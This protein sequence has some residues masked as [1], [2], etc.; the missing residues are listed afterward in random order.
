MKAAQRQGITIMDAVKMFSTERKA[1]DW[2]I[3]QRWADG[4]RC[5]RCDSDRVRRQKTRRPMPF[6]CNPCR[7]Y[8]SVKTGTPMQDSNLPLTK[9][10]I[11]FYLYSTNLKGVSSNKLH[12]DL[13]ITQ[14]SAW[15]MA[16][17]IR[18]I[19]N[20]DTPKFSGP[21]EVDETYIG[22]KERNKHEA[23]KLHAGRGA[24][25]KTAVVGIKD[26][27][28]N[29]VDAEVVA[30]TDRGTLHDFVRRHTDADA[31]VYTDDAAA[32]VGIN[33]S[34]EAVKHSAREYVRGQA[35]TN[36]IESMWAM[37]KRG[38]VGTYHYMS[39]KHLHRYVDEFAGRR[40]VR[41]LDTEIQMS[42]MVQ[43]MDGKRLRYKDLIGPK[44]TRQSALM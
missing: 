6:Y 19:W 25:G 1:E 2:F 8:F 13:G 41:P 38:Y 15:H 5:P 18:E 10:A 17:R 4:L 30:T 20:D 22:G 36:G 9:W 28:T 29:R 43:C 31:K 14:S 7:K 37:L 35:H 16:H 27:D 32:Y 24:V 33:R 23:K 42:S 12:R 40:N 11:G 39:A 26:R 21:V 34:H 3:A 44:S